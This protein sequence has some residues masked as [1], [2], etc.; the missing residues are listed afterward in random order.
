MFSKPVL[1]KGGVSCSPLQNASLWDKINLL[2]H[3]TAFYF[4]W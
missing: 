3:C 4:R 1:S 2:S